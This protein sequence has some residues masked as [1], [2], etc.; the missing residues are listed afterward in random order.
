MAGGRLSQLETSLLPAQSDK[1]GSAAGSDCGRSAHTR[2]PSTIE[3]K[4]IQ[5]RYTST[6]A[7]FRVIKLRFR[8]RFPFQKPVLRDPAPDQRSHNC[9]KRKHG[10]MGEKDQSKKKIHAS[11]A[12]R[13][14]R[15][16]GDR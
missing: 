4:G 13:T 11:S 8:R 10:L 14:Q 7:C 16:S 9:V 12:E 6:G 3:S 5:L 2:S 15:I 1:I